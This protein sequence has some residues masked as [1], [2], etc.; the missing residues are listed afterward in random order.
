MTIHIARVSSGFV[1]SEDGSWLDGV[2]ASDEAA[3]FAVSVDPGALSELWQS[4]LS[5]NP[6]A[7]LT[8]DD[9]RGAAQ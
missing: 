2:Y 3:R 5:R 1:V 7:L 6:D 4:A 9:L 8:L